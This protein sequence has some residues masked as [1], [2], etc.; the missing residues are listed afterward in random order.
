MSFCEDCGAVTNTQYGNTF[1]CDACHKKRETERLEKAAESVQESSDFKSWKH[2][3]L[4]ELFWICLGR[5]AKYPNEHDLALIRRAYLWAVHDNHG[6][7]N[8]MKHAMDWVGVKL[9]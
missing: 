3:D 2:K 6:L 9:H 1:L 8:S 7:A 5:Y 4:S